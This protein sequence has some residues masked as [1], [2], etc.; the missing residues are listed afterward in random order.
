MKRRIGEIL[1]DSGVVTEDIIE[2]ALLNKRVD[3]RIGDYLVGKGHVTEVDLYD[4]LSEQLKIP[5]FKLDEI[6]YSGELLKKITEGVLDKYIVFPIEVQG[7]LLTLAMEDPLD[8]EAIE[9]ISEHTG[10]EIHPVFG[11]KSEILDYIDK[12]YSIDENMMAFF[13][14]TEN[15]DSDINEVTVV[16]SFLD[17]VIKEDRIA[18]VIRESVNGLEIERGKL[19]I[20]GDRDLGYIMKFIGNLL[21]YNKDMSKGV[22][23][24]DYDYRG[25]RL[26]INVVISGEGVYNRFWVETNCLQEETV[27]GTSGFKDI[28]N[29]LYIVSNFKFRDVDVLIK[30]LLGLKE[31]R[32]V[33]VYTTD[34]TLEAMGLDTFYDSPDKVAFYNGFA[35][36]FVFERGW[37]SGVTEAVLDLLSKGRTVILQVPFDKEGALEYFENERKALRDLIE[38]VYEV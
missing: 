4:S 35:D 27:Y 19:K 29:G 11:K 13:G 24:S 12:Y 15:E 34:K 23:S 17:K 33:L 7:S 2:E 38:D 6:E 14:V 18:F 9:E 8:E 22:Y 26:R 5:L 28:G 10:M 20:E 1:L 16:N 21:G 30:D 37:D 3:Q 25:R 32:E 31:R 36:V